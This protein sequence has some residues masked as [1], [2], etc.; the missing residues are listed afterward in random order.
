M[1]YFAIL[2][3]DVTVAV[4]EAIRQERFEDSSRMEKLD[5]IFANH[6]FDAYQ[7]YL[8]NQNIPKSWALAFQSSNTFSPSILQ[9][10][11]AGM[12]AHINYDLSQ[13][14][15]S[16]AP[17]AIIP[18][19]NDFM[20]VNTIL[21]EQVDA[22]QDK[23]ARIWP[24][25]GLLD[26]IAGKSDEAII[27]FSMQKAREKAWENAT[28]LFETANEEKEAFRREMDLTG[29]HYGEKVIDPPWL[30]RGVTFLIR[31]SEGFDVQKK[32][33]RLYS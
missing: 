4:R 6:Y 21:S 15:L 5:V 13:A 12:N 9:H 22:V 31:L 26:L 33:D 18:L 20:T 14:V 28:I 7:G 8:H 16:C 17:E 11:L 30:V 19:K 1:A 27:D 23:L 24:F 32:I 29:K 10:I 2:Y 25:M 3:H